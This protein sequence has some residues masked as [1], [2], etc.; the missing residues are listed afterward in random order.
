MTDAATTWTNAYLNFTFVYKGTVSA[1]SWTWDTLEY[2]PYTTEQQGDNVSTS[3]NTIDTSVESGRVDSGNSIA[4]VE[5]RTA[6]VSGD[7]YTFSDGDVVFNSGIWNTTAWCSTSAVPSNMNDV[8]SVAL[9]ELG[10]VLGL[11]HD[12]DDFSNSTVMGPGYIQGTRRIALTQR[13]IDR[14]VWLFGAP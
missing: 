12:G 3:A 11:E 14:A 10:H 13:D 9:H 5:R 6:S 7:R 2:N 4:Q 8:Q 1:Q